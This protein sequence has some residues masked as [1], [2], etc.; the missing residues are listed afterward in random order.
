[1]DKLFL[2][3]RTWVSEYFARASSSLARRC[4]A[5]IVIYAVLLLGL[6]AGVTV[7]SDTRLA[8]A[9]PTMETVL[10]YETS[11][12]HDR[13]NELD[14]PALASCGIAIFDGSGAR[15]YA[16]SE[17]VAARIHASDLEMINDYEDNQFYEVLR[18][19][20]NGSTR[21]RIT[22][23]GLDGESGMM[24]ADAWCVL[25]EDLTV[26]E[27][28]LFADRGQL[29]QRE[30]DFIKGAY[31]ARMAVERYDYATASGAARTLVLVS[32][33]VTDVSF[34]RAVSDAN[35][36]WLYAIPLAIA[37][38]AATAWYL[39]HQMQRVTLP[40]DRA[41]DAYRASGG[42][43]GLAQAKDVEKTIPVELAPVYRNFIGLMDMLRDA[44]DGQKRIIADLSHDLKTPLAVLYGYAMAF[45]GGRV[46]KEDEQRYHRIIAEKSLAAS[47]LIDTLVAYAKMDHPDY[48]PH[49]ERRHVDDLLRTIEREAASVAEQSGCSIELKVPNNAAEELPPVPVDEQLFRRALLNLVGNA[50]QHNPA[51]THVAVFCQRVPAA[52]SRDELVRIS[53]ADT[54]D[55][56]APEIADTLFDPFVTRN[57]ARTSS[58]GTGLGLAIT[59]KCIS[60]M[61]GTLYVA[62]PPRDGFATE[63]VIDL[64]VAP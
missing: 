31:N 62:K 14:T 34:A 59:Q 63:F 29:T 43:N 21:Y 4:L 35:R 58:S 51:G 55:G 9:F 30:F 46:P 22:L 1:M 24:D 53:V 47:E 40:L 7:M 17:K 23:C 6:V 20:A 52:S 45:C 38:T 27:G 48:I 56:I 18:E 57:T 26:I 11:L 61:R 2:R 36:L 10:T 60:L 50:C 39:V 8:N 19:E 37:L 44:R 64:P 41:I 49:L 25:D 16:S 54:G 3:A 13:F 42:S 32:P 12:E 15:L 33:L 5:C 28:D